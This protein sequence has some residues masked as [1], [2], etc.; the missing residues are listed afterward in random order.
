MKLV[1][2]GGTAVRLPPVLI[3]IRF[4]EWLNQPVLQR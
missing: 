1:I 3:E 2:I 4:L